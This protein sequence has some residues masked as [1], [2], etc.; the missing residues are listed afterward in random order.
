MQT[1]KGSTAVPVVNPHG[2][3]KTARIQHPKQEFLSEDAARTPKKALPKNT[4]L[5]RAQNDLN[6]RRLTGP[7]D[8]PNVTQVKLRDH[9]LEEDNTG[10][11]ASRGSPGERLPQKDPKF[12]NHGCDGQ[13][14]TR[15]R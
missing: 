8:S 6:H 9:V 1:Q 15:L 14:E 10:A 2:W 12:R 5:P 4:K 13:Q 11:V 7:A 3:S